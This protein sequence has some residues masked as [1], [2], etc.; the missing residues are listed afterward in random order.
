MFNPTFRK[1]PSRLLPSQLSFFALQ[2]RRVMDTA[3]K[4][5]YIVSGK[6]GEVR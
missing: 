4:G 6:K 2:G 3:P 5:V 1:R